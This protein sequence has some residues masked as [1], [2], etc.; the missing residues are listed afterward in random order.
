MQ[1]RFGK[2]CKF[3]CPSRRRDGASLDPAVRSGS[4]RRKQ[5]VPANRLLSSCRQSVDSLK[6][7]NG[8]FRKSFHFCMIEREGGHTLPPSQSPHACRYAVLG[9]C[10]QS[11]SSRFQRTGCFC[12]CDAEGVFLIRARTRAARSAARRRS[13]GRWRCGSHPGGPWPR[14]GSRK[15][16]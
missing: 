7:K 5:P 9:L 8:N 1:G 11:Q 3:L 15:R 2:S 14:P 16:R 4:T 13:N 12:V 6:G 10:L